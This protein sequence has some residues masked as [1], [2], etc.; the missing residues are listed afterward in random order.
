MLRFPR[1]APATRAIP[2]I[3]EERMVRLRHGHGHTVAEI[4]AVRSTG[5][6]R[7]PDYV[8]FPADEARSWRWS[9]PRPSTAWCWSRTAAAPTS[10]RRCAASRTR[11]GRSSRWTW[12]HEPDRVDRP[13]EPHGEDPG[14]RDR[15]RTSRRSSRARL[16]DGPRARQRGVL[17]AGRLDRHQRQRDEEEPLRQH[18][19]HRPGRDGGLVGRVLERAQV[20]PRESI[21]WTPSSG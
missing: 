6:P 7:V 5:F 8:V 17:D 1:R 19:G 20:A 4:E 10:P 16:H 2:S 15:P 18:R 14:R 11:S 3:G 12:A 9:G 21:G 13:G